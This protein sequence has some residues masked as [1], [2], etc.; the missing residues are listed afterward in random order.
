MK[1]LLKNKTAAVLVFA[2]LVSVFTPIIAFAATINTSF[3]SNTISGSVTLTDDEYNALNGANTITIGV[4]GAK[5]LLSN[6]QATYS[7][8]DGIFT[9][10]PVTISED[11][12]LQYGTVTSE[13]YDYSSGYYGGGG[14]FFPIDV[15]NADGTVNRDALINLFNAN[16]DATVNS[17]SEVVLLPADAL[18]KGKSLTIVLENG[19]SYTLPIAALK[20]EELAKSLGVELKDL[21]IRVEL[22]KVTGDAA[23]KI[24]AAVTKAGGTQVAP[25]VDFK[26]VAVAGTKEQE[27]TTFGQYVTRTIG[28]NEAAADTTGLVGVLYNPTTGEVTFVPS[29]FKTENN[30]TTATLKR[31]GNSIYT[32]IQTKAVS[33]ADL[34]GSWAQKDVEALASKFIV[35]GTSATAFEPKRNITRAEFAALVVRALGLEVSGSTSKFKDVASNKWYA[36]T[37]A[38]AVNAGLITGYEDGTFKPNANITRKELSAI[39]ARAIKF[40]GKDVTLTD[41]QVSAALASFKDADSLG[42]AKG[43]VAVVVSEGIVK[44]Q[45][46][47]MVVGNA[48]ANRAEA[49]TMIARFLGN[50]G[51]IQ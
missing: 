15:I 5:G 42:W 9:F 33:F 7:G 40:A 6:V 30:K 37:V 3:S 26:V 10:A 29:T 22:K 46:A 27:I 44:G 23:D 47:T 24:A 8:K 38:T 34:A 32:V 49:A 31:N 14:G 2:M 1:K 39:V 48:N 36:A 16:A 20:L 17:K 12:Y 21:V 19:T 45:T 25:A 41:A 28:L 18:L 11:T 50:V 35:K 43:E 13:T 51:F 4:Y